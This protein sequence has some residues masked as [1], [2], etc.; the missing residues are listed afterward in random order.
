MAQTEHLQSKY[1]GTGH[2]DITKHEWIENQHR[3]SYACYIGHQSMLHYFAIAE[4]ESIARMRYKFLQRMVSP[5]GIAPV[6]VQ[7]TNSNKK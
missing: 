2:S 6:P 1:V 3:D 4:N 7:N 5:C